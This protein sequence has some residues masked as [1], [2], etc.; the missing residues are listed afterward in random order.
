MLCEDRKEREDVQRCVCVGEGGGEKVCV[1]VCKGCVC[2]V[3]WIHV[4]KKEMQ[5]E[6]ECRATDRGTGGGEER[7]GSCRLMHSQSR[8]DRGSRAEQS[9]D[10]QRV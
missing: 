4:Y 1:C 8:R 9:G 6:R 7:S 2:R 5:V 3:W 10:Q